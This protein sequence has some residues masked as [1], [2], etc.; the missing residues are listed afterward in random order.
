LDV[1]LSPYPVYKDSGV[2]WL[3]RIPV[4]WE[5][6]RNGRLFAQRV[7]TGFPDL[8]ILEVSLRTGVRVRDLD[9]AK[10][11]QL[12]S[13]RERCKRAIRGDIAYNMMRM[14]QGAVGVA[15]TDGLVSPAYVVARPFPETETRYYGY[16][17][18]TAAY[19][20]EVNKYSR[21]IVTDR[22]RLYWDEF[23]QMPS[24]YPPP[25]EQRKIATVLDCHE[26]IVRRFIRARRRMIELLNEQK[27]AIINRAVTH[28]LDP[29]VRLKPS[30]IDWLGDVSGHWQIKPLKRWARINECVLPET[31]D[32]DREFRYLDIGA[33]GT[34]FLV[35]Q[36]E[37]LR[38]GAAP[39]RARRIVRRGDTIIST[40]RTYLKAVYF[41]ADEAKDLIASTGF[42]VLTPEPLVLPEFLNF[43]MQSHGFVERVTAHSIG[44]AYPAIPETRLGAFAVAIPPTKEEQ[45]RLIKHINTETRSIDEAIQRAQREI[46]L[47]REYRTRLIA[48]VVTGKLDVRNTELPTLDE[49]EAQEDRDEDADVDAEDITDVEEAADADE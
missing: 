20:N 30:G 38:F 3:G 34:G 9:N 43:V 44:I 39:S 31:T 6:R 17:F 21:G 4:H 36:P 40:V 25:D 12:M 33:V 32:P 5:V 41:V 24:I 1:K 48:D 14:W 19:M 13:H 29:N 22:N 15:P 28:G 11:K 45:M 46:D 23:K 7:E 26:R 2:P 42:A 37:M 10:R 18:R 16:L 47:I 8:P 27:Q 35:E 49:V